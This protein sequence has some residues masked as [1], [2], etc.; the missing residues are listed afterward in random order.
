MPSPYYNL[1]CFKEYCQ[2]CF[3]LCCSCIPVNLKVGK[4]FEGR[5]GGGSLCS[6]SQLGAF[7][8]SFSSL[9]PSAPFFDSTFCCM[10]LCLGSS[11][12]SQLTR[13]T[14]TNVRKQR[15]YDFIYVVYYN[16]TYYFTVCEVDWTGIIMPIL[17][18]RKVIFRAK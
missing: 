6:V 14:G 7:F 18:K 2:C 11:K 13:G 9:S 5:R 15:I 16:S 17:Q 10:L 8:R 3:L 12:R 1:L 4:A